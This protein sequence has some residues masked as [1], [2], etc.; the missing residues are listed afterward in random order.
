MGETLRGPTVEVR[1]SLRGS[2]FDYLRAPVGTLTYSNGNPSY[3]S[4]FNREIRIFTTLLFSSIFP[5]SN[6]SVPRFPAK[7]M[8]F[9]TSWGVFHLP[10]Q[11]VDLEHISKISI[12]ESWHLFCIHVPCLQREARKRR[13]E[14]YAEP[15]FCQMIIMIMIKRMMIHTIL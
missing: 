4:P 13:E 12:R 8:P 7:T 3:S 15:Q 2:I 10:S 5:S 14:G 11:L 1:T 6:V 9:S